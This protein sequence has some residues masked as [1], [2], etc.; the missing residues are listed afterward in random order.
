[1]QT[2][3]SNTRPYSHSS[4]AM[5]VM[6]SLPLAV[7]SGAILTDG[8][9]ARS[10]EIQWANFSAWLLAIGMALGAMCILFE[11]VEAIRTPHSYRTSGAWWRVLITIVALGVGLA[12]NFIHARD[13]WTSVMPSGLILSVITVL[14]LLA[15]VLVG[16]RRAY[17]DAIGDLP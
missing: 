5:A 17:R 15:A 12:N 4:P 11:L 8:M 2:L 14:L 13:G 6:V 16:S 10:S 9:Y 3:V 7:F 1:M